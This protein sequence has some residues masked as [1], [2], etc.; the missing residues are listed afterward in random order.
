MTFEA[1]Y[2][3]LVKVHNDGLLK[4][5][6]QS[7]NRLVNWQNPKTK[8]T[9]LHY[10]LEK[11][12]GKLKIYKDFNRLNGNEKN[13][14]KTAIAIASELILQG[15]NIFRAGS[16]NQTAYDLINEISL[17]T[18]QYLTFDFFESEIESKDNY[19]T[20]FIEAYNY[21][22]QKNG[23]TLTEK[24]FD[25]LNNYAKND[26]FGTGKVDDK[27]TYSAVNEANKPI[28]QPLSHSRQYS[29]Q[30]LME[31]NGYFEESAEITAQRKAY[32]ESHKGNLDKDIYEIIKNSNH[33]YI[34]HHRD[35][36]SFSCTKTRSFNELV[37]TEQ[38]KLIYNAIIP[39]LNNGI[40]KIRENLNNLLAPTSSSRKVIRMGGN[41][42][43]FIPQADDFDTEAYT[44]I[45]GVVDVQG[46]DQSALDK[47]F[48]FAHISCGQNQSLPRLLS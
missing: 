25:S 33:S 14:I 41:H 40:D 36:L 13:T 7:N 9:F 22:Y 20:Q 12:K 3:D 19:K 8:D 10:V 4:G 17:I 44:L 24:E 32:S 38:R 26:F 5:F 37:K 1:V 42:Y 16:E 29:K 2:L 28:Y 18:F 43:G 15:A 6:I 48:D 31:M 11:L 45:K 47:L 27:F 21:H 30:D 46:N 23:I 35:T 34:R 39:A